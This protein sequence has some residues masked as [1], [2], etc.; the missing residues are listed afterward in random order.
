M[1]PE[2]RY[3]GLWEANPAD[4]H[5]RDQANK[6]YYQPN[7]VQVDWD[8]GQTAWGSHWAVPAA[9]VGG[10]DNFKGVQF[11]SFGKFL[12]IEDDYDV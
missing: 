12:G 9:G 10:T 5:S 7:S 6:F 1:L 11:P 4:P 2:H 3:L 8:H